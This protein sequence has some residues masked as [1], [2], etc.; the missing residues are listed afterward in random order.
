MN[1]STPTAPVAEP[2]IRDLPASLAVPEALPSLVNILLVDDDARNLDVLENILESPDYR[3]IRARTAEEALM[4]L[5][6]SDFA[7]IVLD[8]QMPG[9]TGFELARLIK[10]RKRNQLI[11]I[12]FL[13]AYYNEERDRLSG[14]DIGAVDYLTK[15]I[16]PQILR[17][18]IGVFAE[19]AR[20]NRALNLLNA[21]LEREVQKRREAEE[22]LRCVNA[23][24]E[25]R[26]QERT[27]NLTEANRHLR[28]SEQRYRLIL[29]NA[30]EYA[31]FTVD[32]LGCIATWN[33]GAERVLGYEAGEIIGRYLGVFDAADDPGHN[34]YATEMAKAVERGKAC[35]EHWCVRK[36][37]SRFWG[38][39]MLVPLTAEDGHHIGFLKILRDRTADMRA[40]Q[41]LREAE[42]LRASEREQLRISQDLHD[43]LGQQLAGISCLSDGLKLD[44]ADRCPSQSTIAGRI[45][46]LLN[47]AVA[48]TRALARGLQPVC[49]EP[50]ALMSALE[51]LASHVSELFKVTCEFECPAPVLVEDNAAATHLYRIAQ[52][53]V[54]NAI[55]HGQAKHI[56]I[57]LFITP[58]KIVLVVRDD[59][60][61]FKRADKGGS[62]GLGLRIMDH[63]AGILGGSLSIKNRGEGGAELICTVKNKNAA[64]AP[65]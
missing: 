49:H 51:H 57:E 46:E 32:L 18:K 42:I 52:E 26:I 9:M 58:R 33:P 54:T 36:D 45:S 30:L 41:Q 60:T 1:L 15:P 10:Q 3:L 62:K 64:V 37:G 44:L 39:G 23:E 25:L 50:D 65:H 48:Q 7:A 11:P 5:I 56:K 63:R 47:V 59:G 35:R 40:E 43:G 61:G 29:E 53:G 34:V 19:L 8:I 24:L 12:I 16:D 14:Y 13:T 20:S 28:E 21:S 38:S 22:A 31:V 17:S 4:A 6:Q 2:V 27:A 55:K